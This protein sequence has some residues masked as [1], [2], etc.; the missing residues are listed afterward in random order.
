[1]WG[2]CT[3]IDVVYLSLVK[4]RLTTDLGHW[5]PPL[6]SFIFPPATKAICVVLLCHWV[7]SGSPSTLH[8]MVLLVFDVLC[9]L[10]IPLGFTKEWFLYFYQPVH[11]GILQWNRRFFPQLVLFDYPSI[12]FLLKGICFN[13]FVTVTCVGEIDGDHRIYPSNQDIL[14]R[15]GLLLIMRLE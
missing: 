12:N 15:K 11:I 5:R 7:I 6:W 8:L 2:E 1:M 13:L 4:V 10:I 14:R 3:W 9:D